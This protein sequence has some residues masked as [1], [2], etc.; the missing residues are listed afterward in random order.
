MSRQS[1]GR[2]KARVKKILDKI[3]HSY[4]ICTI[5]QFHVGIPDLLGWIHGQ[6]FAIELKFG[7]GKTSRKQDYEIDRAQNAGAQT[8]VANETNIDI[9]I[10]TL[11]TYSNERGKFNESKKS[12]TFKESKTS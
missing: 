8:F 12:E 9:L 7:K 5:P 3:P 6:A 10:E 2:L 4:W 11:A 1:E